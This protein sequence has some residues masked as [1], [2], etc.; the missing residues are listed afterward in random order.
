M[1]RVHGAAVFRELDRLID[2]G[3]VAGLTESQLVARFVD[4]RDP[5]A[6]EAI[7]SRHGPMVLSLCRVML[8]DANDVDDAFQATFAILIEK[9]TSLRRPERLGPWLYGVAYRVAHRARTRRRPWPIPE[10]LVGSSR[11][12]V[13][14]SHEQIAALHDE[15]QRLP[16]KYRLPLVLCCLEEQSGEE[17]ARRLGWPVGTVHGRLSRARELLRVRLRRHAGFVLSSVPA[18]LCL[19]HAGGSI[20]PDGLLMSTLGLLKGAAPRR[21]QPL[22]TGV[23]TAMFFEKF[24]TLGFF[25][26]GALSVV[27]TVSFLV[28]FQSPSAKLAAQVPPANDEHQIAQA[29]TTDDSNPKAVSRKAARQPGP[30]PVESD[31]AVQEKQET[32]GAKN[33]SGRLLAELELLELESSIYRDAIKSTKSFIVGVEVEPLENEIKN[34]RVGEGTKLAAENSLANVRSS[35]VHL[36]K[37]KEEY[38]RTRE[39]V[40]LLKS[41]AATKRGPD[42]SLE[43]AAGNSGSAGAGEDRGAEVTGKMRGE[44][45]LLELENEYHRAAIKQSMSRLD[46]W[47]QRRSPLNDTELNQEARDRDEKHR[48]DLLESEAQRLAEMKKKYIDTRQQ[49]TILKSRIAR[50]PGSTQSLDEDTERETGSEIGRRLEELEKKVDELRAGPAGPSVGAAPGMTQGPVVRRKTNRGGRLNRP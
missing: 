18:G 8:A 10:D 12:D 31:R 15:I 22:I 27:S 21:L 38:L 30:A 16:E 4:R 3:T 47:S 17:V 44:L 2:P 42:K 43:E 23:L 6:F 41:E 48:A 13:L 35:T 24:K 7:V 40:A 45:D 20:L 11:D 50:V 33:A 25:G 39:Q 14:E 19:T 29:S 1:R 37:L 34:P 32:N 49:I 26:A 9:A 28:A 46:A 5:V 36:A